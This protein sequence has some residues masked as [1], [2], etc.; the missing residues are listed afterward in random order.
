MKP[1][2][3][4]SNYAPQFG[5]VTLKDISTIQQSIDKGEYAYG[6]GKTTGYAKG[7]DQQA[8]QSHPQDDIVMI[9]N[10]KK[11][12]KTKHQVTVEGLQFTNQGD[13]TKLGYKVYAA[14]KETPYTPGIVFLRPVEETLTLD[15]EG[16]TN[17]LSLIMTQQ[18]TDSSGVVLFTVENPADKNDWREERLQGDVLYPGVQVDE[19]SSRKT[20]PITQW[21]N[22][23]IGL[24]KEKS[25]FQDAVFTKTEWQQNL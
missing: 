22:K 20:R 25:I 15:K 6:I 21:N 12:D 1:I 24:L 8:D 3:F 17:N 9:T 16:E 11:I 10:I 18:P 13:T 14:N 23:V 4:S 2:T 5:K 7:M 19:P